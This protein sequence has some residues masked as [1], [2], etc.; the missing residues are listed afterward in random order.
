MLLIHM[1]EDPTKARHSQY[2][3]SSCTK[4]LHRRDTKLDGS[5]INDIIFLYIQFRSFSPCHGKRPNVIRCY[6]VSPDNDGEF[7]L[8][9]GLDEHDV[10]LLNYII[11]SHFTNC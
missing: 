1:P 3:T 8:N 9:R 6:Q 4:I 11:W 5:V 10:M 7:K 2:F